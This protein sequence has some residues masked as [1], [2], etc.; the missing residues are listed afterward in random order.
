MGVGK[1]IWI[2]PLS[3]GHMTAKQTGPLGEW[4]GDGN[5]E[6]ETSEGGPEGEETS[7]QG[8][9]IGQWV[10]RSH[11]QGWA[12][13]G[14]APWCSEQHLAARSSPGETASALTISHPSP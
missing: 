5:A 4:M 7:E 6:R 1:D 3:H 10:K 2:P 12:A 14:G 13:S 8:S 9:G 11:L